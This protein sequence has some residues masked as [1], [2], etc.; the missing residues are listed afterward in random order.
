MAE[1]ET[2]AFELPATEPAPVPVS[3]E[4]VE[5]RTFGLAP[6]ALV[7]AIATAAL[8][9]AVVLLSTGHLVAGLLALAVA[10]LLGAFYVAEA[11]GRRHGAV[12]RATAAAVDNSRALAGFAHAA[13]RAWS[14]AGRRVTQLRLEARRVSRER[15]RLLPEL[16]AAAYDRD[17]ARVAELCERLHALDTRREACAA[18]IRE[19][20]EEARSRTAA[21]RLAVGAT[22][23][24]CP[25]AAQEPVGD[26]GFEPG[27]SALSERRSN[28]LS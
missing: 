19:A 10:L 2:Q 24:R 12:D 8:A 28:Q 26:P 4:Q 27:T 15:S 18:E 23:V 7:A 11:R 21:E 9:I 6:H 14:S 17:D 5:R 22:G 1:P 13:V 20:L 25:A 16:G 3:Y